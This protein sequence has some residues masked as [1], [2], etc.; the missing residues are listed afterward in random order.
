VDRVRTTSRA[1]LSARAVRH[2]GGRPGQLCLRPNRGCAASPPA[3]QHEGRSAAVRAGSSASIVSNGS[4]GSH[5]GCFG[6][7]RPR[8]NPFHG[9]DGIEDT[10]ARHD[11]P[12]P[13]PSV[14]RAMPQHRVTGHATQRWQRED[15]PPSGKEQATLTLIRDRPVEPM[16]A[17]PPPAMQ[18]SRQYVPHHLRQL[19]FS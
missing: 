5:T 1:I 9:L 12:S 17:E 13:G 14:P 18:L 8:S 4:P 7:S 6:P 19:G 11:A 10:R 3:P 16:R 15:L 2:G